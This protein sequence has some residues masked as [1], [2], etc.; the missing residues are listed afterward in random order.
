MQA[1]SQTDKRR[2]Q[3][4]KV[5]G[6]SQ[7]QIAGVKIQLEIL[8][9]QG[10]LIDLNISGTSM[11][12]KVASFDEVGFARDSSKDARI[13]WIRPGVKYVIPEGPVKRLKSAES[14]ARQTLNKYTR[15]VKGF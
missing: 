1:T 14:R 2:I 13:N 9:K 12:T 4:A 6:R 7:N 5:S 10:I 15:E 8:R 11:F 3:A